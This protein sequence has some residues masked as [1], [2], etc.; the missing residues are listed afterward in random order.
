MCLDQRK[1][2]TFQKSILFYFQRGNFVNW[3]YWMLLV[4]IASPKTFNDVY[5]FCSCYSCIL[6]KITENIAYLLPFVRIYKALGD[7]LC[8]EEWIC[9]SELTNQI[10][11]FLA[12]SAQW[13]SYRWNDCLGVDSTKIWYFDLICWNSVPIQSSVDEQTPRVH[14]EYQKATM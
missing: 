1:Q 4:P 5:S 3:F 12:K 9:F 13:H 2:R 11:V 7:C 10:L 14:I 6:P 8:F